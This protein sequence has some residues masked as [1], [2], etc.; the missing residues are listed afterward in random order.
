M[1]FDVEQAFHDEVEK[2]IG[3]FFSNV[4]QNLSP[5]RPLGSDVKSKQDLEKKIGGDLPFYSRSSFALKM[6]DLK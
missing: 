4:I 1:L 2:T 6:T 3:L 5:R